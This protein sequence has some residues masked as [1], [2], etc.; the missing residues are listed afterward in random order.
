LFEPLGNKPCFIALNSTIN[1]MLCLEHPLGINNIKTWTRQNKAPCLIAE[2]SL[3]LQFH[4]SSPMW[5]TKSFSMISRLESGIR[6][7]MSMISSEPSNS[8][9]S[10]LFRIN[11]SHLLMCHDARCRSSN[12]C[13][14]SSWFRRCRLGSTQRGQGAGR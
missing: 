8:P 13:R 4:S 7:A 9:I 10:A 11:N 5:D 12:R 14:R 6:N 2:K 1:M 3:I